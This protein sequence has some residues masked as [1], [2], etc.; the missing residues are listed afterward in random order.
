MIACLS[1]H[2]GSPAMFGALSAHSGIGIMSLD[3][4]GAPCSA[5]SCTSS[6]RWLRNV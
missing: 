5:F 1:V 6:L 4:I 2:S 3:N